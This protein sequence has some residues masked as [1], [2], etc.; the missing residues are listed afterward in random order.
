VASFIGKANLFTAT[1]IG[2]NKIKFFDETFNIDENISKRLKPYTPIKFMIR[3]EDIYFTEYQKGTINGRVIE[4]IYKGQMYS[5]Q[6]KCKNYLILVESVKQINH[7][8]LV[9]LD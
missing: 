3:P 2:H 8:Q 7:N 1:Y 4:S 5:V 6:V 9:G